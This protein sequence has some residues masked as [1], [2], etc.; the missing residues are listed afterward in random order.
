[1]VII[2]RPT[3]RRGTPLVMVF[4][5]ADSDFLLDVDNGLRWILALQ[6]NARISQSG[7]VEENVGKCAPAD[8]WIGHIF[9]AEEIYSAQVA[10]YIKQSYSLQS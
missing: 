10:S 2:Q 8:G 4:T 6:H 7:G 1:M 3:Q 5:Q 9:E